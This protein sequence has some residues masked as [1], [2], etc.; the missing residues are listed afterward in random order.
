MCVEIKTISQNL[1]FVNLIAGGAGNA[2]RNDAVANGV[3][4]FGRGFLQTLGGCFAVDGVDHYLLGG[5]G[6]H[7]FEPWGNVFFAGVVVGAPLGPPRRGKVAFEEHGLNDDVAV[8]TLESFDDLVHLIPFAFG[9]VH[10]IN[11]GWVNGVE[12]EDVVVH[13]HQRI[14]DLRTVDERGI[15]EHADLGI[16]KILVA[17]PDGVFNDFWEMRIGRGFTVAGEGEHVG[18]GAICFHVLQFGFDGIGYF[19]PCRHLL[20]GTVVGIETAFAIDAVEGADLSV[21]RKEIDAETDAETAAMDGPED[22]RR[23]DNRAHNACKSSEKIQFSSFRFQVFSS[24]VLILI[25]KL[26]KG[27]CDVVSLQL[28]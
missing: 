14:V 18:M 26:A 6:F 15:G 16:R 21:G 25:K 23:I 2:E 5:N 20:L 27:G 12:L 22:G 7:G 19:F 11:I 28:I 3:E 4:F 9:T 10:H 24:I 1:C 8:E 13:F 17:Q